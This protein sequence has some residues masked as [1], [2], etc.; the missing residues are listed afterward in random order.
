MSKT[1]S[2]TLV[3]ALAYVVFVL[4]VFLA[5]GG[6]A[7]AADG[8]P[9]SASAQY[10]NDTDVKLASGLEAYHHY[11]EAAGPDATG[12]EGTTLEFVNS[13]RAFG[14]QPPVNLGGAELMAELREQRGKDMFLGGFRLG[15]LR[16]W[17]ETG[18]GDFFPT[19]PHPNATWGQ[20][21]DATCYPLPDDEY[22]GN[23][24]IRR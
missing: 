12:P 23:P 18:V 17:K 7:Y 14:N 6:A 1:R 4:G 8:N 3:F 24:N 15:D 5:L 11:Y 2:S 22:E 20:Y 19:G 21:G 9:S 13:R 10:E 16:R